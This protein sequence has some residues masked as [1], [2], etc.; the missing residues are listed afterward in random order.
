LTRGGEYSGGMRD[1]SGAMVPRYADRP[2][3][4]QRHLPGRT[5][6]PRAPAT[7]CGVD[8]FDPSC[9]WTSEDFLYGVDLWNRGFFWEAHEAWE[10]PWRAAGR[11]TLV[12][13]LLQGYIL[14]AAAAVKYELGAEASARRLAARGARRM[15][16]AS[17]AHPR[18]DAPAFA[19][20]VDAWVSGRHATHPLLWIDAPP[21]RGSPRPDGSHQDGC[22]RTVTP[23]K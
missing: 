14:L 11:G 15:G 4:A 22:G 3:P 21:I 19:A 2:L 23:E 10:E 17:A 7:P 8:R 5:P 9:W 16:E 18:F 13:R 12:G 6:R 1:T 20:A